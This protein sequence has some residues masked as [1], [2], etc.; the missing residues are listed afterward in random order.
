MKY[1]IIHETRYLFTE[2]VSECHSLARL[3]PRNLMYQKLLRSRFTVDPM[4]STFGEHEDVF[5]NTMCYF[6]LDQPHDHLTVTA[7]SVVEV[8]KPKGRKVPP[9]IA[10]LGWE[11][12]RTIL[13]ADPSPACMEARPFVLPSPCVPP[14]KRLAA[15]AIASFAPRRPMLCALRDLMERIHGEF[16]FVPGHTGVSTPLC[17]VLES[18]E[19]LCQD[20][21]HFA[22]GCLRSLGLAAR[23]VS[24]YV[25][26]LSRPG[27]LALK[28]SD[29]P[30]AW[31]SVFV[32]GFGWVDYD[33]VN[34]TIAGSRY[35]TVAIGRDYSDVAPINGVI[36]SSGAQQFLVTV[37]MERVDQ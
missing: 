36:F 15:Y 10:G 37:D 1:R 16:A 18:R 30:H 29:A 25:E 28:G 23:Y 33:P 11:D 27:R 35:V 3:V 17:E 14:S 21:A 20:F 24:G 19:G 12:A 34:D 26:T 2:T 32:P 9:E 22:I 7:S 6:A 13:H 4:P 8:C 5:N 31:C